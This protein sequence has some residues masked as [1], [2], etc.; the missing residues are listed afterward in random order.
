M[1]ILGIGD[2]SEYDTFPTTEWN[3]AASMGCKFAI[4][5]A[6]TTGA[7]NYTTQKPTVRADA[8]FNQNTLKIA[9]ARMDSLSYCWFDPRPQ[10][11]AMEQA[12]F[13]VETVE[14]VGG[15]GKMAVVDVEKTGMIVYN[16]AS[17]L[18]LRAWCE[19]VAQAGY[20]VGIYSYPSGIDELAIMADI[21]WMKD[22]QFLVAHWDVTAPRIPFPWHPGCQAAWQYTAYA[23]GAPYGFNPSAPGKP[24]LRICLAV[25]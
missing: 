12:T 9:Q 5:R 8:M 18:R 24:G 19:I 10:L 16:A 22:Y 6:T 11:T 17:I 4:V 15:P 3:K 20:K 21:S 7:W 14:K 25:M 1:T 13:F 23:K 2:A